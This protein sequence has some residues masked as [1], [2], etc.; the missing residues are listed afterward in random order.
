MRYAVVVIAVSYSSPVRP[1]IAGPG[2]PV[3]CLL[4]MAHRLDEDDVMG[5]DWRRLWSELIDRPLEETLAKGQKE[6][7]TLFLLKLWCRM[8]PTTEAT[9][10][11]L[12][13]GLNA[14]YRNDVA[15]IVET[16]IDVHVSI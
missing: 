4:N 7:P 10:G 2:A 3:P 15:E 12:I 9:V 1:L 11:R 5:D 16:C 13:G 8:K 6:G 14:I